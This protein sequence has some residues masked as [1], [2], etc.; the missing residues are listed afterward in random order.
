MWCELV[1]SCSARWGGAEPQPGRLRS[2]SLSTASFRLK[3]CDVAP[4][5]VARLALVLLNTLF[6]ALPVAMFV[7][8]ICWHERKAIGIATIVT[9]AF[10]VRLPWSWKSSRR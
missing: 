6:F 4:D 7:S 5:N 1:R 9:L 10:C 3:L 2:P 8:V